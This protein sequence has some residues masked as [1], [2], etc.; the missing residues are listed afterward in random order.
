MIER[1]HSDEVHIK[2]VIKYSGIKLLVTDDEAVSIIKNLARS[3]L[4]SDMNGYWHAQKIIIN[5]V[6][7]YIVK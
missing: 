5:S 1:Y 6:C 7:S 3:V 2:E 4:N